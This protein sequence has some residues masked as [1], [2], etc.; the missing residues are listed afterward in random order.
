MSLTF[1]IEKKVFI[2]TI[3]IIIIAEMQHCPSWTNQ[4]N[5]KGQNAIRCCVHMDVNMLSLHPED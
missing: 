2:I 5:K 3:I 4:N 1:K